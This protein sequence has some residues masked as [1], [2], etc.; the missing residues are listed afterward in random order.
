MPKITNGWFFRA[1]SFFSVA[2]YLDEVTWRL[3]PRGAEFPLLFSW[4]GLSAFLRG[5][6]PAPGPRHLRRAGIGAVAG[7]PDG[8]P[9]ADAADGG[10]HDLPDRDGHAFPDADGLSSARLLRL[11]KYGLEP[12]TVE[13]TDHY[14]VMREFCADP[15]GFVE[16]VID[17]WTP[18]RR[19]D[20]Q[21][22]RTPRFVK[23]RGSRDG[24]SP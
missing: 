8:I 1:E 24:F 3:E 22:F 20:D 12:V 2:R 16:G 14:K 6:L 13:Q 18:R 11:T 7:A 4:R 21:F 5:A 17:E 15:A 19:E 10:V 23:M 9:E